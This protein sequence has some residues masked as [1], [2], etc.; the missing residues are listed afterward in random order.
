VRSRLHRNNYLAK[1]SALGGF[2]KRRR[3]QQEVA[4]RQWG[5][6]MWVRTSIWVVRGVLW[7]ISTVSFLCWCFIGMSCLALDLCKAFIRPGLVGASHNLADDFRIPRF[8]EE[9]FSLFSDPFWTTFLRA[10]PRAISSISPFVVMWDYQ[11]L[12]A[13]R[14]PGSQVENL[15]EYRELQ[16]IVIA[17]R[18]LAWGMT[19]W[20]TNPLVIMWG[21]AFLGAI[22]LIVSTTRK[23]SDRQALIWS[24]GILKVKLPPEIA[25]QDTPDDLD[26]TPQ[27]SPS[28]T[29]KPRPASH[30][31]QRTQPPPPTFSTLKP[32]ND[33]LDSTSLGI[34]E[35]PGKPFP[36]FHDSN[37]TPSIRDSQTM[38]W[39]PSTQS[40]SFTPRT[41]PAYSQEKSVFAAG[42]GTLPPAPGRGFPT[43]TNAAQSSEVNWLNEANWFQ[44][45]GTAPL[46]PEPLLRNE[47]THLREQRLFIPQ[48]R[49]LF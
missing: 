8:V 7:W 41:I 20:T 26:F 45:T 16:V 24:L 40:N 28:P 21:S 6:V 3:L 46:N 18:L 11:W 44:P 39:T 38:D 36:S 25:L 4:E 30:T 19:T 13:K 2:L 42:R 32:P 10:M 17:L 34:S 22:S 9:L 47:D 35:K 48:V 5:V 37:P 33:S 12:T 23:L 15:R 49:K 14:I 43:T 27:S 1:T 29:P 31:F